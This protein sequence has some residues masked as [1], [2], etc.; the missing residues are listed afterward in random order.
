[1]ANRY[2]NEKVISVFN[3][4]FRKTFLEKRGLKR[5]TQYSTPTIY[6]PDNDDINTLIST[7]HIWKVGDRFF[8]LAHKH[9]NDS[10]YWWLIAW[11]NKKPTESHITTGEIIYIPTPIERAL[12]IYLGLQ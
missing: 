2:E 9:Y 4:K 7:T 10:R 11:Y 5:L 1:M 6:Y 8:K 12:E 3:K